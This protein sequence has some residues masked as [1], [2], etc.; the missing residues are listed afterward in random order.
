MDLSIIICTWNNS[1]RLGLTLQS[2][3]E[4][5]IPAGLKWEIVLVNN[6]CT[7]DTD[8]VVQK[9][10]DTIPIHYVKE[11]VQ[12]L[13]R[14][15]NTGLTAAKGELVLFTDDDVKP[16]VDWIATYWKVYNN[17]PE[18]YFFGG[19]VESEFE[20]KKIDEDLLN[21]A[22]PSVKGLDLG[23]QDKI[24]GQN[25]SFISGN[26]ACPLKPIAEAG[27]FDHD[28]GLNPSS[29][30][31]LTGEEYDLME[32]LKSKGFIPFYIHDA[33]VTHFVPKDKATLSHI[34]SRSKGWGYY[35]GVMS[36]KT[37]D[38][39][40]TISGIPSYAYREFIHRSLKWLGAK[41]RR[42]KGYREYLAWCETIGKIKGYHNRSK[43]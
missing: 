15:K 36:A 22:P 16:S 25:E 42:Q 2:I 34:A 31:V 40:F 26:W 12:G 4:C 1:Q 37:T 13:S 35:V 33:K 43:R 30:S 39:L 18:N 27:G 5:R 38:Q 6:N 41:I 23:V 11:P 19:P 21:L 17:K 29:G 8:T 20:I 3:A 28:L 9:F 32:R 7:D 10:E 14:A 24:L